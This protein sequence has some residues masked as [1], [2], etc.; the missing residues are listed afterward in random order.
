[1]RVSGSESPKGQVAYS[2]VPVLRLVGHDEGDHLEDRDVPQERDRLSEQNEQP[3]DHHYRPYGAFQSLR[4]ECL[5]HH[6]FS[7]SYPYYTYYYKSRNQ[8][9]T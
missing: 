5:N 9:N 8:R 1:M 7:N 6:C 3:R 4:A 2:V